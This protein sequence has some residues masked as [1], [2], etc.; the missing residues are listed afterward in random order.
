MAEQ[1][2]QVGEETSKPFHFWETRETEIAAD[3][4]I[5]SYRWQT[6]ARKLLVDDSRGMAVTELASRMRQSAISDS[7]PLH[8]LC[9][10][11][12]EETLRSVQWSSLADHVIQ[13]EQHHDDC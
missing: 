13:K 2:Q 6:E 10:E 3:W 4:I 1:K 12:M 7:N 11:L 8:G 5:H 9:R